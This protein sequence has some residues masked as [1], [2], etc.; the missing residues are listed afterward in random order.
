MRQVSDNDKMIFDFVYD[1]IDAD[2]TKLSKN[3]TAPFEDYFTIALDRTVSE[4]AIKKL[5]LH[6]MPGFEFYWKYNKPIEPLNQYGDESKT[7][8]FVR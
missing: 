5:R 1:V 2:L 6:M 3:I 4:E 8:E 7:K